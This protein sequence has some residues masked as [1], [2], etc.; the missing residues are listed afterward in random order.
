MCSIYG[1]RSVF[2]LTCTTITVLIASTQKKKEKKKIRNKKQRCDRPW[3]DFDS[4]EPVAMCVIVACGFVD[5]TF[6]KFWFSIRT[7]THILIGGTSIRNTHA[8]C[9]PW[10]CKYLINQLVGE[11]YSHFTVACATMLEVINYALSFAMK[12]GLI[13]RKKNLRFAPN[14]SWPSPNGVRK[15]ERRHVMLIWI[16]NK[17]IRTI[18]FM[19]YMHRHHGRVA[20]AV[21]VITLSVKS[22]DLQEVCKTNRWQSREWTP[23][24][25]LFAPMYQIAIRYLFSAFYLFLSSSSFFFI[26]IFVF[27]C[28]NAC[29]N[30]K[31]I[32]STGLARVRS[33]ARAHTAHTWDNGERKT[34]IYTFAFRDID[35]HITA[36]LNLDKHSK[37]T[38]LWG[39]YPCFSVK[40][41]NAHVDARWCSA[42][43]FA[44]AIHCYPLCVCV[45]ECLCPLDICAYISIILLRYIH[46]ASS[47]HSQRTI[48][49]GFFHCKKNRS[50]RS[51]GHS[52]SNDSP[53]KSKCSQEAKKKIHYLKSASRCGNIIKYVMKLVKH[54]LA[55]RKHSD[56]DSCRFLSAQFK[57]FLCSNI[58]CAHRSIYKRYKMII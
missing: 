8:W 19:P 2:D 30:I 58:Q 27:W 13:K 52:T 9:V 32:V 40:H 28:L 7:I 23:L 53:W 15:F 5:D 22:A 34:R 46:T 51:W 50:Q 47:V 3:C 44:N 6:R 36:Y 48:D 33:R 10:F 24:V 49:F 18:A 56:S 35:L 4:C 39:F 12:N 55:V 21:A 38:V 57:K 20:I 54:T 37:Y 17:N 26:H 1:S 45:S 41:R 42:R 43:C 11:C 14:P 16:C 25:S 31:H 29:A